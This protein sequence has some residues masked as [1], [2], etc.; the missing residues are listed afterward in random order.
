VHCHRGFA[1]ADDAV[2]P[3]GGTFAGRPRGWWWGGRAPWSQP[4][5][6]G[7]GNYGVRPARFAS[8]VWD[9][10]WVRCLGVTV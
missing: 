9:R 4:G 5:V 10:D 6:G 2:R 8:T 1:V 3:A 7:S